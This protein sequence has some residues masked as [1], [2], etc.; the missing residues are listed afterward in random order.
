MTLL[1]SRLTIR[2]RIVLDNGARDAKQAAIVLPHQGFKLS[3]VVARNPA[4]NF[5]IVNH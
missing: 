5:R 4:R 1:R 2:V 3:L